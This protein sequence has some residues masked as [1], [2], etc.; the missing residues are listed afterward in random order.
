MREFTT[1][2]HGIIAKFFY[3]FLAI[4]LYSCPTDESGSSP[5]SVSIPAD[6]AG[7]CHSGYSSSDL[8]R[9][10]SILDEMGVVWLHRDFSWGSIESSEGNWNF[11]EFDSY[12]E[13]ANMEGKKIMG[14][15]LYDVG[16][17]HDKFAFPHERRLREEQLPYYV[18]YAVETVKRYNGK[19]GYGTVDAWLIWNEPDLYPRFWTGTKEE[20]FT[21]TKVTAKAIRELDKQEGTKT[22]L[23]GGVFSPL[24]LNDDEWIK[25]LFNSGAM[26]QV[27]F[28][29]FHPYSIAP[30]SAANVFNIFKRYVSPY[31]F[32]NKIF[33]NE[34]G[35]PTYSDQGLIPAGR[36][37]TDQYEGDMPEVAVKTFVLLAAAGAQNL[38]WYHLFDNA[39][40][41]NA[42]SE[43]WFGLIW[44]KS[45]VEWERKGGYWGYALC[46][47]NISGKTYKEKNFF[48][49]PVSDNIQSYYFEGSDGKHTLVVWN[50]SPLRNAEVTITLDGGNHQL[51]NTES[52]ESVTVGKNSTHT[53]YP[54]NTY[55]NTLIFLTWE[56]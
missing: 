54:V 3:I 42:D 43:A 47:K 40:R 37:G 26:S 25:G 16:W 5:V 24:A 34:M 46:A 15:L 31:G 56:D 9:E 33:V 20:F 22:T 32:A 12:V 18:N 36:Y 30:E 1:K 6:F 41:N 39:T 29:S 11:S 27:D 28:V 4:V 50:N 7:M 48:G 53:L 10:Y 35:Y 8:D 51:W 23:I 19:N 44:R 38:T 14:M 21:L 52:G 17:V 13:R 49:A 45:G 2:W 55:Q